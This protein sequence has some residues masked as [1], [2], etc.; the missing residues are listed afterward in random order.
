MN[1]EKVIEILDNIGREIKNISNVSRKFDYLKRINLDENYVLIKVNDGITTHYLRYSQYPEFIEDVKSH[2][3]NVR[4]L[5]DLLQYQYLYYTKM[6]NQFDENTENE[7][8]EDENPEDE[9]PEENIQRGGAVEQGRN[10]LLIID[11]LDKLRAKLNV[12]KY[13]IVDNTLVYKNNTKDVGKVNDK[14]VDS[15]NNEVVKKQ[16]VPNDVIENLNINFNEVDFTKY[17]SNI[18]EY[19]QQINLV[20]SLT[21]NTLTSVKSAM[22]SYLQIYNTQYNSKTLKEKVEFLYKSL[23]SAYN[24]LTSI[25]KTTPNYEVRTVLQYLKVARIYLLIFKMKKTFRRTSQSLFTVRYDENISN[26]ND[27]TNKFLSELFKDKTYIRPGTTSKLVI[28]NYVKE[29]VI[30]LPISNHGIIVGVKD[31]DDESTETKPLLRGMGNVFTK[32]ERE[33]AY[34]FSKKMVNTKKINRIVKV[35]K[36]STPYIIV[37]NV[38]LFLDKEENKDAM[39]NKIGCNYHKYMLNK[40]IEKGLKPEEL[41]KKQQQEQQEMKQKELEKKNQELRRKLMNP[42]KRTE[43][44]QVVG[45]G[46]TTRKSVSRG[47]RRTRKN[48]R[49]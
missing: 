37:I 38:R 44:G 1:R 26:L 2:N 27:F 9:N 11:D 12:D 47:G 29:D 25:N 46:N 39:R 13:D 24:F 43:S 5:L 32:A 36:K 28:E 42:T 30:R 41:Q 48:R 31:N 14:N 45:K 16:P 19:L 34:A 3:K 21:S 10:V 15:S 40:Y 49:K 23:T 33:E 4:E 35:Q 7:N 6:L 17:I 8:P 18:N 22:K 20:N